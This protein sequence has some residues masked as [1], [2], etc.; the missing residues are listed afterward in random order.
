MLTQHL[1]RLILTGIL[2]I[3]LGTFFI[4][5]AHDFFSWQTLSQHYTAIKA[6]ANDKQWQ[7]HLG[8]LCAYVVAVTFSLPI[9]SLLSLAGGAI[10][11]WPAAALVVVAATAGAGLVFLAARNIFT[12]I[13]P[14]WA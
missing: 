7:S 1:K 13:L 2:L 14:L 4:S 12:D 5:G 3:G 6:F 9:A 11:G 10:L 8:F